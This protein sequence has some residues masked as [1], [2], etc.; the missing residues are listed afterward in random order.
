MRRVQKR[1]CRKRPGFTLIEVLVGLALVAISVIG[2]SELFFMTV[3]NNFRSDRISR[4]TFLAQQRIEEI[5]A[6]TEPELQVLTSTSLDDRDTPVDIN[7]DGTMDF[8]TITSIR[9]TSA[10]SSYVWE[11][12]VRVFGAE[13]IDVGTAAELISNPEQ[14]RVLIELSTIVTR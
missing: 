12:I 8:R 1:S 11:I 4:A 6:M 13:R 5:R 9:Q 14:N 7:Q 2:L 3:L 10:T